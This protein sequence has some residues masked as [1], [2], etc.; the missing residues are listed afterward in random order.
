MVKYDIPFIVHQ[1]FYT[2]SLPIQ[3]VNII[4]HN[5]KL[6]PNYKFYFYNDEQCEEFIKTNFDTQVY[7]AYM[8]L[9][10]H[11][12]AMK[13]DFFRYCVLYKLGGIYLDIKSKINKPLGS[14]IKHDDICI[15]DY[16]RNDY[17]PW[18]INNPT[19]EQWLL[20]FS[21]NHPYLIQMINQMV[22]DIE[23][24]YEPKIPGYSSL[25]PKQKV[26]ILTGPDAFTRAINSYINTHNIILHRSINYNYYFQRHEGNYI[27]M[28]KNKKHY[29]EVN[30]PLYNS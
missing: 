30:L 10:K 19:Y 24:N 29:S 18:R 6:C 25:T 7:N 28:Y 23:N 12:G 3:I 5:Q 1:T 13:A 27:S 8:K 20:I 14:I 22:N 16:L 9:N 17:E 11:Y 21:P 4:K 2:T 26:L 15:L